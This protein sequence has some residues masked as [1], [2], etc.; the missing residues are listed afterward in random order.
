MPV[1][2]TTLLSGPATATYAGHT[3]SAQDGIV[4][5]PAL[6][7]VA[8]DSD[9]QGQLDASVT[10]APL[11]IQFAPSA[12]LA[13]LLALYPYLD[14]APGRLLF[15]LNDTPL[16]LT[17]SN[18]VRLTFAAVAI[19]QMPELKLGATGATAAGVTFLALGART[20]P[21]TAANR[22]V[23]IDTIM[24]SSVAP[25]PTQLSDDFVITWGA[26][27]WVNMRAL[28]GV[29][30]RFAT[31]ATLITSAANALL[32]LSLESLTVTASFTPA[33]PAGPAEADVIAALQLQAAGATPGCGLSQGA[34]A[35]S[36]AGEHLNVRLP[37]AQLTAAPLT[38]D[39]SH[40][41]VG[42]LV[43]TATRVL[44]TAEPTLDPIVSLSEG[45]P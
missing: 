32:D 3:F 21:I 33:T 30:L 27:P 25:Q 26:A 39:S 10:A 14:A 7:L 22:L 31:K 15:G 19:T 12:P 2:R 45:E 8:V 9:A 24:P 35:L 13:D 41:R 18:G 6:E 20:L 23:T 36:I 40:P 5:T 34:H 38:Y 11:K 37:L 1:T 44:L 29:T 17:A 28:D 43:F 16:V 4:I 42:E